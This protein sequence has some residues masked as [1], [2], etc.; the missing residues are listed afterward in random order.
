MTTTTKT[1]KAWTRECA[2]CASTLDHGWTGRDDGAHCHDCHRTWTSC[3]AAHCPECHEHFT[4]YSASD[5]HDGR[6]GCIPPAEVRALRR[7]A[8]GRAWRLAA[9]RFG[10]PQGSA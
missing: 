5:H 4:S 8:D 7:A 1:L 10:R 2:E 9:D 3:R 6:E